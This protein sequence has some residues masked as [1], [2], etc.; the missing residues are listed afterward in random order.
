MSHDPNNL[1]GKKGYKLRKPK[2]VEAFSPQVISI[3]RVVTAFLFI[4]RAAAKLFHASH[5]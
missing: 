1:L 3:L 4:Q 2:P 5:V